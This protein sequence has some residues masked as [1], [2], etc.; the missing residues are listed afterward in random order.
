MKDTILPQLQ[1]IETELA[2]Q[3]AE[4]SAQLDE[5]K[6]KLKGVRAVLPMFSENAEGST[7]ALANGFADVDTEVLETVQADEQEDELSAVETPEEAEEVDETAEPLMEAEPEVASAEKEERKTR[8]K[9]TRKKKDG[10]LA[11]WQKYVRSGVEQQPMPEA[12]T[13]I[14]QTQPEKS[15]KIAEVMEALFEDSIPKSQYL[16]ARNRI[17][18]ILS[19]GARKG[20]W[21]RGKGSTYSMS[22]AK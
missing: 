11:S 7:D 5:I 18:N 6:A 21:N 15:F 12:V 13:L 14:L 1:T 16:K 20:E 19:A 8:K 9:T 3:E 10:R 22:K 17:S 4:L 2:S